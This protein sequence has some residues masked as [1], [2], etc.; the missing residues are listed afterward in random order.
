[1]NVAEYIKMANGDLITASQLLT[2]FLFPPEK[3]F[4]FINKLSGGEKK[5]LQ[6]LRVLITNPNF[7][8][9]DEPSND[10]DI[11]TLNVLEEFLENYAGVLLLVSH[12][13]YLLDKLTDQ[14]FIFTDSSEVKIYNGNYSD[15][16]LEQEE[17]EKEAKANESIAAKVA[18]VPSQLSK[19]END[20]NALS[21]KEKQELTNLEKEIP[22]LESE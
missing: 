9:L 7:L 14:L 10:L 1:K 3:Q 6:L 18:V 22:L 15:Y 17:L 16:K 12:D 2:H 13:R 4:G 20:I 5:R 8:I 19:K 11:D 21:F